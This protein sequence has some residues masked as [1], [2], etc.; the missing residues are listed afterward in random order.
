V[1][2][3]LSL[4]GYLLNIETW[5]LLRVLMPITLSPKVIGIAKWMT[6]PELSGK[7]SQLYSELCSGFFLD[8]VWNRR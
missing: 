3:I 4:T 2:T 7:L 1:W 5:V 6:L 8:S